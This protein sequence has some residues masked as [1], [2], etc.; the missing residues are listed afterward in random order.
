V[1]FHGHN[2]PKDNLELYKLLIT[3][4]AAKVNG[5]LA[6]DEDARASGLI[7]NTS[8]YTDGEG[9]AVIQHAVAALSLDVVLVMS[10]DKL[11]STLSAAFKSS[12]P[13]VTVVKLPKSGG[14]VNKVIYHTID[15]L[16]RALC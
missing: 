9:L 2:Q 8:A 16:R 6:L 15:L 1:Y 13:A 12:Q 14:V 4:L 11:Y 10:H 5:R 3:N 7:V